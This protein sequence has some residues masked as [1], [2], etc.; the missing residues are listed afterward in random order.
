MLE[1]FCVVSIMLHLRSWPYIWHC[2]CI[3]TGCCTTI[4]QLYFLSLRLIRGDKRQSLGKQYTLSTKY[5]SLCS[6]LC[7]CSLW[8]CCNNNNNSKKT[9]S[10]SWWARY[11]QDKS[12]LSKAVCL[13]HLYTAVAVVRAQ[14]PLMSQYVTQIVMRTFAM[15]CKLTR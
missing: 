5:T 3:S 12:C 15:A 2:C 1:V 13:A 4:N 14:K 9:L 10:S 7:M 8:G 11:V 6:M